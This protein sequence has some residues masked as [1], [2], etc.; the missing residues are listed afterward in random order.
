MQVCWILLSESGDFSDSNPLRLV[1]IK[2]PKFGK[3]ENVPVKIDTSLPRIVRLKEEVK[4][5]K[6]LLPS[7]IISISKPG[8]II[9]DKE[10]VF[11]TNGTFLL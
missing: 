8:L 7:A 1:Q 2:D 4:G 11:S 5:L 3:S 9:D 6:D 10:I